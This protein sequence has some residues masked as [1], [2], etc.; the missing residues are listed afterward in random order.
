MTGRARPALN[1]NAG[2][3]SYS[4]L[5]E[6]GRLTTSFVFHT[7]HNFHGRADGRKA[8]ENVSIVNGEL[9]R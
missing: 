4:G 5:L 9:G 2:T 8:K 7:V 1:A 6:I 3:S